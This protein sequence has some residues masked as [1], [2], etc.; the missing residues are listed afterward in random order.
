MRLGPVVAVALLASGCASNSQTHVQG[1]AG[2][3][4]SLGMA[5]GEAQA[6]L[7]SAGFSCS[8]T[9][10]GSSTCTR[11]RSHRV[12]ASCLQRVNLMVED[13]RINRFEVPQPACAGF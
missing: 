5:T 10:Q 6:A 3:L 11:L 8:E 13:G 2:R 7:R 12:V 9:R 1:E 4:V